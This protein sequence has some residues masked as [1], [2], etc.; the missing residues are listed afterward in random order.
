M[1]ARLELKAS[2]FKS[3]EISVLQV[4]FAVHHALMHS[5]MHALT[6][7][8]HKSVDIP[9]ELCPELCLCFAIT[10][11]RTEFFVKRW[12]KSAKHTGRLSQWGIWGGVVPR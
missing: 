7:A 2:V 12:G 5:R 11:P 3:F 1:E 9:W 6:D 10:G 8:I 4:A